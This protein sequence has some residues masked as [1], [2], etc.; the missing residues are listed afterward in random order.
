MSNFFLF[1]SFLFIDL[2]CNLYHFFNSENSTG[3]SI[4]FLFSF[5]LKKL[6]QNRS[7]TEKETRFPC[8]DFSSEF[9]NPESNNKHF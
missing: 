7:A 1:L 5:C 4:T 8:R 2:L 3:Y 6:R 9:G